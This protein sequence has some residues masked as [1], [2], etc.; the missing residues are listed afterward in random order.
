[1]KWVLD[2]GSM[3]HI[4]E[5]P[6]LLNNYCKINYNYIFFTISNNEKI[7]IKG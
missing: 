2:S 7:R 6:T 4:T 3:D 1:M 5:N